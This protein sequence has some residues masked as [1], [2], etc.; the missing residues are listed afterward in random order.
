ME[1][2]EITGH[3]YFSNRIRGDIRNLGLNWDEFTRP[4]YLYDSTIPRTYFRGD[5]F[6][7]SREL[8]IIIEI[9]LIVVISF[10]TTSDTII[11]NIYSICHIAVIHL[12]ILYMYKLHTT[13]LLP[14]STAYRLAYMAPLPDNDNQIDINLNCELF[15]VKVTRVLSIYIIISWY[16]IF[17][18]YLHSDI[19]LTKYV[20]INT[21]SINDSSASDNQ[22][23]QQKYLGTIYLF[24]TIILPVQL[25]YMIIYACNYSNNDIPYIVVAI[26][27]IGTNIAYIIIMWSLYWIGYGLSSTLLSLYTTAYFILIF[28][29]IIKF[30]CT[31]NLDVIIRTYSLTDIHHWCIIIVNIIGV[32]T[33]FLYM[34]HD[35]AI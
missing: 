4:A 2:I 29:P 7:I 22:E 3:C 33:F 17:V 32:V 9:A 34:T 5:I 23:S 19:D 35:S 11:I 6:A 1:I 25:T 24:S 12:Y 15:W 14:Y 13:D 16:T 18:Y 27:V 31:H 30:T 26:S 20:E 28:V 10:N 8:W 21:N